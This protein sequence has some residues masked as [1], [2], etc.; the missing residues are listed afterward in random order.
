MN[1]RLILN[2][3]DINSIISRFKGRGMDFERIPKFLVDFKGNATEARLYPNMTGMQT[4]I[5]KLSRNLSSIINKYYQRNNGQFKHL[6][7]EFERNPT[8][9]E[10]GGHIFS[11]ILHPNKTLEFFDPSGYN[12]FSKIHDPYHKNKSYGNKLKYTT[13]GDKIIFDAINNVKNIYNLKLKN[14]S[15][16]I[17]ESGQCALL[18]LYFHYIR[19]LNM[20]ISSKFFRNTVLLPWESLNNSSKFSRELSIAKKFKNKSIFKETSHCEAKL[21]S[22]KTAK[23]TKHIS[24]AR[25]IKT[26]G[27]TYIIKP[28]RTLR[29]LSTVRR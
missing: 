18:S 2:D 19:F 28:P 24:I 13:K 7:L 14:I 17:N 11:I 27:K 15:V 20:N 6:L 25:P 4:P 1:N 29:L 10:H 26:I 22:A 9:K 21:T 16:N 3:T 12:G 5:N 8:S 23:T